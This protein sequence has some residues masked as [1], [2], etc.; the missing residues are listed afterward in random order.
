[1]RIV[2]AG[3]RHLDGVMDIENRS[4][5][6]A[7]SREGVAD[8]LYA[9]DGELLVLEDGD[10]V[11]GFAIYHVSFED[12]ELYNLA[13]LPERRRCGAGRALL[14]AALKGAALRGARRMFLEVRRSNDAAMGLYRSAGFAVC[15]VRRDYYDAP[16]EDAVLMDKPL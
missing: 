3:E 9:P 7:W 13:V 10:T 4:F 14:D 15:G 6:D 16:R 8:Y 11:V 5:T 12:A 1:M 2:R